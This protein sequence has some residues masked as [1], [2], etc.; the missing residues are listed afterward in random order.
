MSMAPGADPFLG[1]AIVDDSRFSTLTLRRDVRN[2][3]IARITFNRPQ[4]LNAIN[5]QTPGDIRRAVD[6]VNACSDLQ[7]IV[8]QGAGAA[9]CAGYDIG[10]FGERMEEHTCKQES[11]PCD[12]MVD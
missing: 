6:T 12:P 9:F 1:E 3:R 7:V 11:K 10:L 5:D 4:R 8:L 2:P